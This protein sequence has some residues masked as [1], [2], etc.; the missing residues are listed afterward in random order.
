[1]NSRFQEETTATD[2][3][4]VSYNVL[5]KRYLVLKFRYKLL[6]L[7]HYFQP[8]Y[9]SAVMFWDQNNVGVGLRVC[10]FAIFLT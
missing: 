9:I 2:F 1:M 7:S 6:L 4:K 10:M 3:H 5:Q 8:V